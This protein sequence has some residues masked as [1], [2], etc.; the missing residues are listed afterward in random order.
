MQLNDDKAS[1]Q[2]N[3]DTA[4]DKSNRIKYSNDSTFTMDNCGCKE[5]PAKPKSPCEMAQSESE[6][7]VAVKGVEDGDSV[8]DDVPPKVRPP[9][10]AA[11]DKPKAP[12]KSTL[13][14]MAKEVAKK[15]APASDD[16][17]P[18]AN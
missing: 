17:K 6:D 8:D 1:T 15:Q 5:A 3:I 13:K 4:H 14:E 12:A 11:N 18:A 10:M 16:D 7:V 2:V 9:P